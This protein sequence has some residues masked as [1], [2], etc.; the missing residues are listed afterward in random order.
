MGTYDAIAD[1]P[2]RIESFDLEPHS[3]RVPIGFERKTTVVR[4]RGAGEEG[5][6]EDVTYIAADQEAFQALGMA[7]GI[8]GE[9]TLREFS[10]FLDSV[11]FW[12]RGPELPDSR[13][14]RRWAFESAALDLAL[15]QAGSGFDRRLGM[16][17]RPVHFVVSLNLGNP[18]DTEPVYRML[19]HDPKL[20]F[21]LD[22]GAAWSDE[23]IAD[24]AGTGAI[25]TIDLKGAYH[26]TPVDLAP[27][28]DLYRRVVEGFPNAWIEDPALTDATRPV[29][30]PHL[31]RVTWD[32][33]IHSLA[34]VQQ[35]EHTPQVLNFKPSRFGTLEGLFAAYDH[36]RS[37][38][39]AIYGG[40]QF[41][42][43]VGRGQVQYLAALF[44]PD[45]P[46]DVA[47]IGYSL[48]ES[49]EGQPGSPLPPA[50]QPGWLSLGGRLN[51]GTKRGT[52]TTVVDVC[53]SESFP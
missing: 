17:L 10:R 45:G 29:L 21:K 31:D 37:A 41:E 4:L 6:G 25:D 50:L 20:R 35:L 9:F 22:A 32:A 1:L 47:P 12:P 34:D 33:P 30:Q 18:P 40:G 11:D 14:F 36:C 51:R 53:G 7:L 42:L 46:N 24:L 2:V 27:D 44:H 39:I 16:T 43:S 13:P 28:P 3:Y 49:A 5:V 23:L 48:K 15:R 8:A 52:F 19:R 26:G 38:G